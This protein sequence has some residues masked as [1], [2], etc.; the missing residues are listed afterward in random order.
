MRDRSLLRRISLPWRTVVGV[1]A[2]FV[3][4]DVAR[5]AGLRDLLVAVTLPGTSPAALYVLGGAGALTA[6]AVNNLPAYRRVSTAARSA[7]C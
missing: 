4:V 1:S 2:L 7:R 6:D 3:V 5:T